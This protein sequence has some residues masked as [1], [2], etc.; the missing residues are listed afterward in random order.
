MQLHRIRLLI[1]EFGDVSTV[2]Y[3]SACVIRDLLVS[4]LMCHSVGERESCVLVDVTGPMWLAHA[5]HLRQA[6]R[7]T[8]LVHTRT[9]V[10][11]VVINISII[12]VSK[13]GYKKGHL[14]YIET[15]LVRSSFLHQNCG[16][17]SVVASHQGQNS[18]HF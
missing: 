5:G 18:R 17:S 4:E 14:Q 10:L 1:T 9:D 3:M 8:R 6:Q 11:P 7:T 15:P 12:N 16:L 13:E 2:Y